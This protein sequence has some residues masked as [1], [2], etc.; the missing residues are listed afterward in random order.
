VNDPT[1]MDHLLFA[2]FAL[3]YPLYG[4]LDWPNF[5]ADARSGRRGLRV[6]SYWEVIVVEWTLAL[7][8]LTHWG[9]NGRPWSRLGLGDPFTGRGLLAFAVVIAIG[10]LAFAHARSV[11]RA[12]AEELAAARAPIG[13]V[14]HLLPQ[15]AS[16]RR[17]FVGVSVTAG[18]C[19][20]LFFR[21][22]APWL[23]AMWMPPWAAIVTAT[24]LFGLAHAYQGPAGIPQTALVGAVMAGLTL[25]SGTLWSAILLHTIVDLHGGSVGGRI[26]RAQRSPECAGPTHAS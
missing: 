3:A 20:E 15:T 7:L 2:V 9:E 23:L 10:V 16:E 13:D 17:L 8:L 5:L 24:L 12:P 26:A 1:A 25:W 18:A 6:R 21:G 14:V 4:Y 11:A 19:E 22:L